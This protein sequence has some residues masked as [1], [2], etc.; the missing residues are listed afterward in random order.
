MLIYK[1]RDVFIY[2]KLY[3]C[4]NCENLQEHLI[5]PIC[6]SQLNA[7]NGYPPDLLS[8]TYPVIGDPPSL[9]GACQDSLQEVPVMSVTCG[10]PGWLGTPTMLQGSIT[11][12]T[13]T[14]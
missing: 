3:F 2:S 6:Q 8:T 5:Y 9:L 7:Y 1:K 4:W 10:M 14:H 12:L 11:V 13:Q